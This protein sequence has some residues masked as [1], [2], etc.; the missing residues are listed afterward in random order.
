MKIGEF[1]NGVEI[2]L[3][4][5]SCDEYDFEEGEI[6]SDSENPSDFHR[7]TYL[8]IVHPE[9]PKKAWIIIPEA[10]N[11]NPGDF[12]SEFIKLWQSGLEMSSVAVALK[13]KYFAT[14]ALS[15]FFEKYCNADYQVLLHPV[16]A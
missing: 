15:R 7:V 14:D 11:V 12:Y 10:A 5:T 6:F 8:T 16:R 2:F 9:I 3:S 4:D 13:E 1:G